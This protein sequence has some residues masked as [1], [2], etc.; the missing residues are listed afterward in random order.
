MRG[1]HIEDNAAVGSPILTRGFLSQPRNPI[2]PHSQAIAALKMVRSKEFVG[3]VSGHRLAEA[4]TVL[5]GTPFTLPIYPA[6][7]W[8]LISENVLPSLQIVALT[9]AIYR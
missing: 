9:P 8:K 7:A 2:V 5:T 4:D 6:E 1:E 3:H